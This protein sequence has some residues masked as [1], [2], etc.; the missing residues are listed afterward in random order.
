MLRAVGDWQKP[1]TKFYVFLVP[2]VGSAQYEVSN[3]AQNGEEE[4]GLDLGMKNHIGILARNTFH[5]LVS[6]DYAYCDLQIN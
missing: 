4:E 2:Y 1:E 6:I 5:I 3:I